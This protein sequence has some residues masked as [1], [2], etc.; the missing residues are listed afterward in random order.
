MSKIIL[1]DKKINIKLLGDSIT[2]G[3]GGT[4]W[5]QCGEPIV[6]DFRRSPNSFCWAKLFKDHIESRY[7]ATVTNNACTGTTVQFVT[8]HFDSLVSDDDDIIICTIGTN[9]RH[10]LKSEGVHPTR[11][12]Q[13]RF[14]YD[15]I[16]A[17]DEKMKNSGKDY[18]FVANIPAFNEEDTPDA[19]RII[20]MNDI[21]NLYVK[22]A[23]E[24]GFAFVDL[25]TLFNDYCE[26]H[27]RSVNSYL[28]DGLHPTDEGYEVMYRL[29]MKEFGIATEDKPQN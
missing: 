16:L 25:Y 19:W 20:H 4:G 10:R 6:E 18:I 29:L 23:C 5:E 14:V 15:K 22:A 28:A 2:H 11:E 9:N 3:V 1:A 8:E 24:H 7:N 13:M 27:G 26:V 12:E 17:L 21:H